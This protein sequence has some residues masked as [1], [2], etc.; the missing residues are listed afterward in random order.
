MRTTAVS[1]NLASDNVHFYYD[2]EILS[3]PFTI[4]YEW[5]EKSRGGY[6]D[7]PVF[8]P[9]KYSHQSMQEATYQI[10][11]S[12][13]TEILKYETPSK[14]NYDVRETPNGKVYKWT[15]PAHR[16][17]VDEDY[18]DDDDMRYPMVIAEPSEFSIGGSTGSLKSWEEFGK[19]YWQLAEGRDVL[20]KEEIAKVNSLT[21]DCKT[22]LDK[23]KAL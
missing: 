15:F 8:S 19:W 16:H 18:I 14:K 6:I 17:L 22:D 1:S 3:Y 21:A 7:F 23:I 10:T 13:K 4:E 11:A 9:M 12:P 20:P 2:C 5:T